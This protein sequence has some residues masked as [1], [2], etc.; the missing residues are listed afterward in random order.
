MTI[1]CC[2]TNQREMDGVVGY[3]L[4]PLPADSSW[5]ASAESWQIWPKKRGLERQQLQDVSLIQSCSLQYVFSLNSCVVLFRLKRICEIYSRVLGS[6][7]A[8][9]VSP[10]P[11]KKKQLQQNDSSWLKRS[12]G[13]WCLSA[14]ALWREELVWGG[15]L[16]GVLHSLFSSWN[17]DPVWQV[18][19]PELTHFWLQMFN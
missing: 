6:E 2:Y 5:L 17:A 11:D 15:V 16:W 14:G 7:E 18:S 19:Y 12:H 3:L 10:D 8:L 4:L 1:S 13:I 9:H